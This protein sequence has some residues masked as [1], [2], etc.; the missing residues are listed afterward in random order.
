MPKIPLRDFFRNPEKTGFQI[1]PNAK[2]IS[3]LAPWESRLNIFVQERSGGEAL[4]ITSDSERDIHTYFWKGDRLLY[5]QDSGG[6]ENDHLYIADVTGTHHAKDLTPFMG[7]KV[8]IVDQL[9]D[10]DDE[11]LISLNQR[12]PQFF[13]VFRVNLA[14]GELTMVLENSGGFVDYFADHDGKLRIAIA[15]DGVNNT[16]LYRENE[17]DDLKPIITTSFRETLVPQLFTFDNKKLYAA[18]N[19]GRDKVAAIEFDPATAKETEVIFVHPENDISSISHS[20]KRN[21]L[22]AIGYVTWKRERHFLDKEIE[23]IFEDIQSKTQGY[24]ATIASH[25]KE[26][27]IFVVRTYSD[28]SLGAFYLYDSRTKKLDKLADI[29]PWLHEEDLAEQRP[30]TYT[31]RDGLTIHGYLTLPKGVEPKGL[32][33]VVNPHGGPWHRDVWGY[34][35]ELQFLANRG[36]AVFQ[37]NFRGSTS[38]GKQFMQS[39]FKQWG[40]TMQ[41]D[42]TDGVKWLIDQGIANP[43]RIAIYGGSYG[44]Y[45][46]LAGLAFTPDLYACG[47]DYVGVSNLFTFLNTIPPYWK[48]ML[49]MMYEMVGHP[50]HDRALLESA[51]PVFHVDKIKAPLFVVQGAKDPRVNIDESDQIVNALRARGI[52]VPYLVK[53]NEGH[54]FHNEENKFEFYGMFEQFLE[55]HI[56]ASVEVS[57]LSS[58]C[59]GTRNT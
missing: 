9:E 41:D 49:E 28:R 13:D 20:R 52:D 57:E 21:V 25:D 31:S 8:Q 38:Y 19:I 16:I 39:S 2:Y 26:E 36:Y 46:T 1:S 35:P 59:T 53:E 30:I 7:V 22:T 23:S 24:E 34:N 12:D 17:Q 33:V 50:V 43:D 5:L 40:K 15:T 42:V 11:L 55:K 54:G 47:V 44:G 18:S 4:R 58:C 10:L 56:G 32:P 29:S 37:M 14:T 6:D 51:S 27:E 45:C 3:F 48:P